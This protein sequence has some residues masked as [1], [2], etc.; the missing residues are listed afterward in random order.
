MPLGAMKQQPQWILWKPEPSGAK[1]T[2]RPLSPVTLSPADPT[3]P[4]NWLPFDAAVLLAQRRGLGVGFVLTESDPF[5]CVDLDNAVSQGQWSPESL[6]CLNKFPG[7]AVEVS[8]SGKGLH[9]FGSAPGVIAERSRCADM[10]GLEVYTHKRFIAVTESSVVGDCSTDHTQALEA[11]VATIGRD[12]PESTEWTSRPVPEWSGPES[13]DE[14]IERMVKSK[15]S[16]GAVFGGRAS[17]KGLWEADEDELSAAFPDTGGRAWDASAADAA[18]CQHLAFWTGKNCDR[19]E[20]LFGRSALVRDKWLYRDDYRQR[21]ITNAA[22]RCSKVLQ[23]K[24][25]PEPVEAANTSRFLALENMQEFFRGCTYVRDLH[26]VFTPDGDLL[27]PETFRATYGGYSFQMD[28][29]NEIK[30]TR[31]AFTALTEC[32]G[33]DFPKV[34]SVAFRP[35]RPGGEVFEE[36]GKSFVNMYVPSAIPKTYGDVSPFIAHLRKVLPEKG[37]RDILLA[38]MAACVQYP[39]VKFQWMPV[40][41]GTDGNGKSLFMRVV[42]KAVGERWTHFPNANDLGGNGTKFTGWLHA[43]MFIGIEE[44]YVTD[45]REVSDALKPMITNDK[46]EIQGK[47]A[48]QITGDNRANFMACSN[49]KDAVVKTKADRRYSPFFTAQ[50]S[51]EDLVRDGMVGEYFPELYEWLNKGGYS[52]VAGYLSRYAIPDSLNPATYCHRAPE[53]SSTR[54]AIE[55]SLGPIEQAVV[56]ATNAEVLGFRAG[57]ISSIRL[58][59]YL[60]DNRMRLSRNKRGDMLESLG[61]VPHPALPKGRT[62]QQIAPENGRPVLYVKADSIQ[63]QCSDPVTAY[64][65]A[66]GYIGD[67]PL[68]MASGT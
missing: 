66:Q 34:H 10:P 43:K 60:T 29:L 53:T 30:P 35:E 38:Y 42:S 58:D 21:T 2:K 27:K 20:R 7:A 39:G 55:A 13:D 47:G 1:I 15:K 54:E 24:K 65:K 61:Y 44:M 31:N 32:Q 68:D 33:V 45:R 8:Q 17:L 16:A 56:E 64:M 51:Y 9:V 4:D 18:L 40:L 59:E 25:K 28:A 50:Q 3:S 37:D 5:F 49:R 36:E 26:C 52:D 11:L 57:W 14:L 22:G 23:Q 62:T 48:N 67:R 6:D 46:I 19:M 63:S 12:G 41:Q